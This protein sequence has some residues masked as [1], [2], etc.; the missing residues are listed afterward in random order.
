MLKTLLFIITLLFLPFSSWGSI[1]YLLPQSQ[2]IWLGDSF[3]AEVWL[4][5]DGKTV[6]SAEGYLNF[7]RDKLKVINI[8]DGGSLLSL[9]LQKPS[10]SNEQGLVSF[11]GGIPNGFSG[12]GRL[13]SITFNVVAGDFAE[14]YFGNNS[15]VLLH[16]GKG[17]FDFLSFGEASY[18]LFL[19]PENLPVIT[20]V[21]HPDQNQWYT[22]SDLELKWKII[23]GMEYSYLLSRDPL[24]A[25]DEIADRPE[26]S[27][28]WMGDMA[29]KGLTDGIYYFHLRQGAGR[30][31]TPRITYR[32]MI[33]TTA[34]ETFQLE[35]AE[36]EGKNYLIFS[37]SD[38]TS[39]IDYYEVKEG[40]LGWEKDSGPYLLK[41]QK[42]SGKI[43]VRAVDRAGNERLAEYTLIPVEIENPIKNWV[44]AVL[45]SAGLIIIW[46]LFFRPRRISL[47]LIVF[48]FLILSLASQSRAQTAELYLSPS[49]GSFIV[50]SV[51]SVSVFV[52]T[53]GSEINTVFAEL[54]FPPH[55]LQV[56]SPTAGTSFIENWLTPPSYS[57]SQGLITFRGGIPKG[58]K[59]SAGLIST[60]TFRAIASGEAKINFLEDSKI[61]LND[62]KGTDI[63][64]SKR[65][66]VFNILVPEPEGPKA[67]SPTHPNPNVWYSDSSPSFSWEGESGVSDF[68]W[69]F[70]QNPS[71]RPD[72][73]SDG[74][75]NETSFDDIKDGIWYFHLRQKK[76][77][78][79]GKTSTIQIKIDTTPPKQFSPRL[80]T[81]TKLVGYQTMVYFESAD[82]FSGIDHYEISVIDL[83]KSETSPSFFTEE[84]SPYKVPFKQ[85]GKYNAVI[86]AIDGA[87][88]IRIAEARFRMVTPLI[89]HIEGKGI[90]IR[91][92]VVPWPLIWISL[93]LIIFWIGFA[94]WLAFKKFKIKKP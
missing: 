4:D 18:Q 16:D 87:G 46:L 73:I 93:F 26:G 53:E 72:G 21:S 6:N 3:I 2:D 58:I 1:L 37:T 94:I 27:L 79:W 71:G 92:M 59:T 11:A 82:E 9:W 45:I 20:S 62:G 60:I 75:G 68:S 55:I 28:I 61:L 56:T 80:E 30:E 65:S 10:F 29:Y 32:A 34:P 84:I 76:N 83:N 5:T 89:S 50:G 17:T 25:P 66:A 77:S 36:I 52:N 70:D 43:S 12:Q 23:E 47:G 48:C 51:F 64:T 35:I 85:G 13:F 42:L 88:N 7:P 24:L 19:K 40:D 41:N 90:G 14:L 81:Y 15:R 49:S 57:N 78:I 22:E 44:I 91:G 39:G 86:R 63:L 38:N 33:D 54:K 74:T 69:I 67:F 8:S 31:W